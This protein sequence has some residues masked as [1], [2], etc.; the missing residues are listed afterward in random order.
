MNDEQRIAQ[1]I[2]ECTDENGGYLTG[3]NTSIFVTLQTTGTWTHEGGPI[4]KG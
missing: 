3:M 1:N 4:R 2:C